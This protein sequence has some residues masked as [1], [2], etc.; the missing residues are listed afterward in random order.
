MADGSPFSEA[1][2]SLYIIH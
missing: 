2:D 1:F